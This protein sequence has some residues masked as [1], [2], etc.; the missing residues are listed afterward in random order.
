MSSQ[1]NSYI[2]LGSEYLIGVNI[3]DRP[4]AI[5]Y[6][7]PYGTLD[8]TGPKQIVFTHFSVLSSCFFLTANKA[9]AILWVGSVFYLYQHLLKMT[10]GS[11][12]VSHFSVIT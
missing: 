9:N 3:C 4:E 6:P 8:L 10:A 5:K 11:T 1:Q 12:N 7:F 2:L